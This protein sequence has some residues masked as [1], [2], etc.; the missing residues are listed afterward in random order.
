MQF[1]NVSAAESSIPGGIFP[2]PRTSELLRNTQAR[3][4]PDRLNN[5]S[6]MN[7]SA[8][9]GAQYK[10][11]I[12]TQTGFRAAPGGL[13]AGGQSFD[14]GA[15]HGQPP[16]AHP[17]LPLDNAASSHGAFAGLDRSTAQRKASHDAARKQQ[18]DQ[19][20]QQQYEKDAHDEIDHN[21]RTPVLHM[22]FDEFASHQLHS[23]FTHKFLKKEV[24]Q[25][26][27][28]LKYMR[29]PN[30]VQGMTQGAY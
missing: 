27:N 23:T 7:K 10:I 24:L 22:Q 13:T 3:I 18:S 25:R 29:N 19:V 15:S 2:S 4:S 17:E 1:P 16:Q 26:R 28:P 11:P 20:R 6:T 30:N 21:R 8:D 14:A 12:S 5:E 9:A